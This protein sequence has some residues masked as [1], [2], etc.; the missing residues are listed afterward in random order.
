MNTIKDEWEDFRDKVIHPE[1]PEIQKEEMK[2]AFYAGVK[3]YMALQQVL[4]T[5]KSDDAA[6]ALLQSWLEE[7]DSY[8]LT[9]IERIDV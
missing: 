3:S 2:L 4:D 8:L 7:C 9:R 1:A 5:I 6:I